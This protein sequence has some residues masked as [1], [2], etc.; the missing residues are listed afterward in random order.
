MWSCDSIRCLGAISDAVSST[1]L[2]SWSLCMLVAAL[3]TSGLAL[4]LVQ[5]AVARLH[6]RVV[7]VCVCVLFAL[8]SG[9]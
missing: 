8:A 5:P 6:R 9:D 3:I 2:V 7:C 1:I 4:S